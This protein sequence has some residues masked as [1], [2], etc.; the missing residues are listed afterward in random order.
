MALHALLLGA[1][2]FAAV[3]WPGVAAAVALVLAHAVWRLPKP[4]PGLIV[5]AAE[6]GWLVGGQ[7]VTRFAL[8]PRSRFAPA[9]V[10]LDLRSAERRLNI[11]LLADQLDAA[12]WRRLSAH[13]RRMGAAPL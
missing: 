3:P 5:V 9:W 2:A 6:G 11:V 12:T 1:A 7:G 13:L 10:R 8:G 4:A